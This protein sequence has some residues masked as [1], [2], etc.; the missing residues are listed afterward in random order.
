MSPDPIA[1]DPADSLPVDEV[2][3]WAIEKH[4]RLRRYISASRGARA[5]FLPPHND[6]GASYIELFSGP[7]RSRI[8]DTTQIIDGSPLVAYKAG[9]ASGARFSSLH[10]GDLEQSKIEALQTRVKAL[11]SSA[12][13]YVGTAEAVVGRVIEA[14]NPY[15]LH[16]AFL[17]PYGLEQ[18]PFSI[19]ERLAKLQRMDML[20]HV[21]VQD[22]QRNLDRYIQQDG[23]LDKF[24]PGWRAHVDVRQAISPL[25][26]ALLEYWLQKI[27]LLGTMPAQGIE[28]VTGGRNQR[29]YWLVFVSAHDLGQK[30]W[31]AVRDIRG[32][33]DLGF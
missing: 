29:L 4:E 3:P 19:I 17:D 26:A 8:R 23:V 9:H 22:L 30:L 12:N 31:N 7:G 21:S 27:R 1:I 28:L 18:L 20:I 33:T 15:G 14:L 16:F 11:G 25:R 10:F 6:G 32:Q 13:I 5:K 2:G 24:M